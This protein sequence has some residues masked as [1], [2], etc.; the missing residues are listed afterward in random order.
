[1]VS[2]LKTTNER[3]RVWAKLQ[4]RVRASFWAG[5]QDWFGQAFGKGL[6]SI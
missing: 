4:G 3:V 6:A 2:S 1:M 5:S